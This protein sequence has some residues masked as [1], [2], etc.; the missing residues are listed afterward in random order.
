VDGART[1]VNT[2]PIPARPRQAHVVDAVGP[3][4]HPRLS[5]VQGRGVLR[6]PT[7]THEVIDHL[8]DTDW[9][10]AC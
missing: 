9:G 10:Q 8:G 6:C 5:E 1:A 7:L 2:W 4:G 3:G